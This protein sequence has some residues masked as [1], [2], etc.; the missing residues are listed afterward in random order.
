MAKRKRELTGPQVGGFIGGLLLGGTAV[1]QNPKDRLF[2]GMVFGT[3]GALLGAGLV[4]LVDPK[5]P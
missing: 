3:M 5:D 4:A 2:A 1:A